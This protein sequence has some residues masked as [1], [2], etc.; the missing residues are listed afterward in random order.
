MGYIYELEESGKLGKKNQE[1]L[2][3]KVAK[4]KHKLLKKSNKSGSGQAL[5]YTLLGY[6]SF[7]LII[8][9]INVI[10]NL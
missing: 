1:W 6:L 7:L 10:L 8:G 4:Y 9:G 2:D 5:G 3:K